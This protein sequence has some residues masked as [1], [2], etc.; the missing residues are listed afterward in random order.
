MNH[1]HEHQLPCLHC[2]PQEYIRMVQHLIER[3]LTFHM[4]RDECIKALAKHAHIQPVVTLTVWRGLLEE[5]RGFFHRY[6]HAISPP[7]FTS[8]PTERKFNFRRRK[9]WK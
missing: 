6:F 3:C 1:V 5:N 9:Q 2:Q 7:H 4:S 8:R